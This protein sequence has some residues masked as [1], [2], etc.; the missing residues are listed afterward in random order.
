MRLLT[1]LL[2]P[3][4][5]TGAEPLRLVA[6]IPDLGDLAAQVGGSAVTVQTLARGDEDPHTVEPRPAFIT[7]LAKAEVL[8][9]VG[10]D[11]DTHWLDESLAQAPRPDLIRLKAH[12]AVVLIKPPKEGHDHDHDHGHGPAH[13]HAA[14]NPHFLCDPVAGA[15]VCLALGSALG[16][17]RPAD[18]AGLKDRAEAAALTIA[19]RLVGAPA[20]KRLGREATLAAL[21]Q[22][23]PTPLIGNDLGGWLGRLRRLRGAPV[24][25]D[26]DGWPYLARRFDLAL[27]AFLEPAPGVPSS[28]AHLTKV[29]AETRSAGIKGLILSPWSDARQ[30]GIVAQA[31]G[32]PSLTLAPQVG[33]VAGTSTYL[34][35]IE[36]NVTALERLAP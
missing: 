21:A 11:Y 8:L 17:L 20:C 25:A 33:S 29:V 9:E 28:T 26:H 2:L 6:S 7:V 19:E 18:A 4:A 3:L 15:Q 24:I 31:L 14:G 27:V 35:T 36:A 10:L 23:D 5:L 34:N 32:V 13:N 16:G 22:S 1:I 12:E 30:A